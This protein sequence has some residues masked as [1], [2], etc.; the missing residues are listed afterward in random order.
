MKIRRTNFTLQTGNIRKANLS[1]KV[2]VIINLVIYIGFFLKYLFKAK[3]ILYV[4][5]KV[6][7]LPFIYNMSIMTP[8]NVLTTDF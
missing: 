8:E 3:N 2:N 5:K 6:V 7:N 1:L 4:A